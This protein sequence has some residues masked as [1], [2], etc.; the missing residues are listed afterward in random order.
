MQ[1]PKLPP[2]QYLTAFEAAAR[3]CSFKLAAQELN[4]TPS[5]I[6]QQ[7]KSL[8]T[9]LGK[10]LFDRSQRQLKLTQ[11]G[12]EFFS[13]A[14]QTLRTY[15]ESYHGFI[16]AQQKSAL[17]ISMMPFIANE[18][19]IPKLADF[20]QQHP[21]IELIIDTDMKKVSFANGQIDAAIRF[22]IPPWEG[23]EAELICEA[24]SALVATEAYF[25]KHPLTNKEDWSHQTLIHCRKNI[26]DWQTLRDLIGYQFEAKAELKFDCYESGMKAAEAGLGLAMGIFPITQQK[27][28]SGKLQMLRDRTYPSEESFYFL[29]PEKNADKVM[30][31]KCFRWLHTC[32]KDAA[33][34]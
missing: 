5:A 29:S 1:N 26:D 6:S 21:D 25:E 3:L 15:A 8:E 14:Q 19:V 18:I 30:L 28:E 13:V 12:D 32:I 34:L 17:V 23:L 24:T 4:V 22:G 27:I 16:K 2:I 33:L 20:Q 31:N 9:Q 11:S 7:I 10:P